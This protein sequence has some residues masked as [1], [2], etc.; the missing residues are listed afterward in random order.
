MMTA[1]KTLAFQWLEGWPL[2]QLDM[3]NVTHYTPT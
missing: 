1:R 3:R 2:F